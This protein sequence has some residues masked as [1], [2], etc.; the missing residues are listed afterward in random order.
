MPRPP[1]TGPLVQPPA[2]RTYVR[3]RLTGQTS[4]M[5]ALLRRFPQLFE[6]GHASSRPSRMRPPDTSQGVVIAALLE[7]R[8]RGPRQHLE[9][10][11]SQGRRRVAGGSWAATRR[12]TAAPGTS[13]AARRGR[14]QPLRSATARC[15][16]RLTRASARSSSSAAEAGRAGQDERAFEQTGRRAVSSQRQRARRPATASRSPARSASTESGWPSS[17]L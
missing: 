13:P 12:A 1:G 3:N 17:A 15:G 2:A 14:R 4:V 9:L 10:V 5:H 6:S 8:Q 16:A 7:Q 11:E